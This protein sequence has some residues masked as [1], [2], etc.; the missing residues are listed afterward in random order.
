ML[1]RMGIRGKILA[2]LSVPVAVLFALAG[3]IS[4]TAVTDARSTLAMKDV[5]TVLATSRQLV[6]AMQEERSITEQSFGVTKDQVESGSLTYARSL[7]D[8]AALRY[9]KAVLELEKVELDPAVQAAFAESANQLGQLDSAR[10]FADQG[11]VSLTYIDNTYAGAL[12]PVVTLPGRIADLISDRTLASYLSTNSTLAELMEGYQHEAVLG[13]EF[14]AGSRDGATLQVLVDLMPADDDLRT[15]V[16]AALRGFQ[17]RNTISDLAPADAATEFGAMRVLLGQRTDSAFAQ[18]GPNAWTDAALREV[19]AIKP[20]QTELDALASDRAS[21]RAAASTQKA[22]VIGGAAALGVL[23]SIALALLIARSIARPVMRLTKAADTVRDRLPELVEQAAVPGQIPDLAI[24]EIPVTSHDEVGRLA[25]AFNDV[26]ASTLRIAQE[27]AA[28]RGS[29]AEM[30]V[31]V[32]RRDQ[33]LLNR[34]L[35]FIDALERSEE[36]PATLADLFRLDH[37]ATRMRRNAESLLVLAGIDTG[38]RLRETLPLSDVVRTASSEIEHYERVQ[39]DLQVDPRMLG[40][41]ALPCAHLLAELL[42]N[43]TMFS[44][45]GTPVHVSTGR[46]ETHVLVSIVDEGLGMTPEERAIAQDKI[47]STSAS[48]VLGAQRLGF[49]VVGRIAARLG[50]RV[51]LDAGPYDRGTRVTVRL[52]LALFVDVADLPVRGPAEPVARPLAPQTDAYGPV[53][54]EGVSPVDIAALTDGATGLGL[55]KRRTV[56]GGQLE[57]A[58]PSARGGLP[59]PLAPADFEPRSISAVP[60]DAAGLAAPPAVPAWPAAPVPEPAE[61][62]AAPAAAWPAHAEPWPTPQELAAQEAEALD[63]SQ[64]IPHA[65]DADALTGAA[66]APVEGWAPLVAAA[67]APL[68]RRRTARGQHAADGA[69]DASP[70]AGAGEVV[71]RRA[72][73]AGQA[74]GA[75]GPREQT[76]EGRASMFSGFR[77]RRAE[78]IAASLGEHAG[79]EGGPGASAAAAAAAESDPVAAEPPAMVVPQLEPD[80]DLVAPAAFVVPVLE[81]ELDDPDDEWWPGDASAFTAQPDA[82]FGRPETA[83]AQPG[84]AFAQPDAAWTTAEQWPPADEQ[85]APAAATPSAWAAPAEPV[86]Q[87]WQAVE[88]APAWDAQ[89]PAQQPAPTPQAWQAVEPQPGWDAPAQPPQAPEAWQVADPEPEWEAPRAPEPA[90]AWQEPQQAWT[91]PAQGWA[92]PQQAWQEPGAPISEVPLAGSVPADAAP[93]AESYTAI[94]AAWASSGGDA[95][96]A[97]AEQPADFSALVDG[98]RPEK[99]GRGLFGRRRDRRAGKDAAAPAAPPIPPAAPVGAPVFAPAD[100]VFPPVPAAPAFPAEP[101]PAA[102]RPEPTPVEPVPAPAAAPVTPIVPAWVPGEAWAPTDAGPG[103]DAAQELADLVPRTPA[104]TGG[105]T[106]VPLATPFQPAVEA[107]PTGPTA[108]FPGAEDDLDAVP[109]WPAS[110]AP[111]AD[112]DRAPTAFPAPLPTPAAAPAPVAAA[113]P[114]PTP[115]APTPAAQPDPAAAPAPLPT[116]G[117]PQVPAQHSMGSYQPAEEGVVGSTEAHSLL[118]QRAGIAQQALAELSQLST[119][120]PQVGSSAAPLTRRSPAQIPQAPALASRKPGQPRDANQVRSLLASFQSGTTRGREAAESDVPNDLT[121]RG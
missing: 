54:V 83:F 116:R 119:Y 1:R 120:R 58:A 67:E 78:V 79:A 88:P 70:S 113:Q 93:L 30:F 40:H 95:S 17:L 69:L 38:R 41:T 59:T 98:P 74:E 60:N 28:L 118:A 92:E 101:A 76:I 109:S 75:Q 62:A 5:V 117:A 65:P 32:A 25:Q 85:W 36:D 94:P 114:A 33:V 22:Y 27:Q 21:E 19:N 99:H 82:A 53:E 104:V 64:T 18:L 112:V 2:A 8:A 105:F 44:E 34:Q 51:T 39:L 3:F 72:A 73:R 49:F 110:F 102:F 68:V 26:N 89:Q 11:Q 23:L 29:I 10:R 46:D 55:P 14:I 108:F 47:A 86:A 35:T 61:P 90:Q 37:L 15:E 106:E 4:W 63:A 77:S 13:R 103:T 100:A 107:A 71:G 52:P 80:E 12:V 96:G 6:T 42:E 45:P 43:A 97:W 121:H 91:E 87:E 57:P 81:P 31:N 115:A 66:A 48:D 24:A 20:A 7:T 111:A 16:A 9:R 56:S 50:A 84:A